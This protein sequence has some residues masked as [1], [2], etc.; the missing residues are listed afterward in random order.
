MKLTQQDYDDLF[1]RVRNADAALQRA[2]LCASTDTCDAAGRKPLE[3]R[4]PIDGE[5]TACDVRPGVR[6][7]GGSGD[8][9]SVLLAIG[10]LVEVEGSTASVLDSNPLMAVTVEEVADG[11]HAGSTGMHGTVPGTLVCA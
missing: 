6:V 7:R 2:R 4:S 11:G 9:A 10:P 5:V 3:V 8:A 1:V